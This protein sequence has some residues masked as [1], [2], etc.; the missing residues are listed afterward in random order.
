MEKHAQP[1]LLGRLASFLVLALPQPLPLHIDPEPSPVVGLTA[2]ALS[3]RSEILGLLGWNTTLVDV[4][5]HPFLKGFDVRET[6]SLHRF[7]R[8]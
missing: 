8:L 2:E 3:L 7:Q 1:P 6:L 5:R 4:N